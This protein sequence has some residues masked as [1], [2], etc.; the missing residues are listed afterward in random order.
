VYEARDG[1][2]ALQV[3]KDRQPDYVITDLTMPDMDGFALL[4]V[5]KQDE[6]TAHIPV[7]VVSAKELTPADRRRLEAYDATILTKGGSDT[8]AIVQQVTGT[9]GHETLDI[10]SEPQAP[11]TLRDTPPPWVIPDTAPTIV[12]IDDN[13]L[14][15]RLAKRIIAS[16][17]NYAVIDANNGRDGLKAIYS[18]HPDL[19]ILD[20]MMPDMDG[21]ALLEIL[22]HDV[23]LRDIPVIVYSALDLQPA[24]R[25]RLQKH[26]RWIV[27]KTDLKREEF[28]SAIREELVQRG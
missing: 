23:H 22:Q 4:A 25:E 3:I 8:R 11:Q 17:G 5:L 28:L 15:I 12:V 21:F 18:H 6:T 19:I 7:M 24:E 20:L 26:I 1:A 14:D 9:L 27:N 10:I 16:G 2:E 13:P